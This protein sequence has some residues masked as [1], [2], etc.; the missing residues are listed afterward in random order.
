MKFGIVSCLQRTS[1]ALQLNLPGGSTKS[2]LNWVE[3][4]ETVSVQSPHLEATHGRNCYIV[5]CWLVL[6]PFGLLAH[7]RFEDGTGMGA[8]GV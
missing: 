4:S 5:T 8:R 3:R 1:A 2:E 7:L 6:L